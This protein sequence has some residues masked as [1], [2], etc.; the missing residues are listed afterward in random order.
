MGGR[1]EFR[2]ASEHTIGMELEFQ[3]LDAASFDL[4][5][6]ILPLLARHGGRGSVKPELVQ[7]SVEV[8]SGI[9]RGLAELAEDLLGQ[10]ADLRASATASGV[11]LAGSGTHPFCTRLGRVT[12]TLRYRAIE[13][14]EGY[15]ARIRTTFAAQVHVG[16]ESG[17]EAI[18]VMR[19]MR[20]YI[21]LLLAISANSPFWKG[22]DT[23]YASFR[24]QVL[25]GA[26]TYGLPPRFTTWDHYLSF[27][28]AARRAGAFTN[29]RDPHWDVRPRPDFGS[30]EVRVMDAQV[31]VGAAVRLG[32]FVQALIERI[33]VEPPPVQPQPEWV[34]RENRSRAARWGLEGRYIAGEDGRTIPMRK[35]L[36]ETIEWVEPATV[37]PGHGHRLEELTRSLARRPGYLLQ[38]RELERTGDLRDVAAWVAGRLDDELASRAPPDAGPRSDLTPRS[39]G[40]RR[41]CVGPGTRSE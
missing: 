25:A 5:D 7:C 13:R 14:R 22:H 31:T 17:E 30:V 35:L 27:I 40:T 37:E 26:R 32:A 10:V 8:N 16:L 33:R 41:A 21:P 39:R 29:F 28:R 15:G 4:A 2:G 23:G 3:I 19:C 24:Q 36:D 9:C 18:R 6:R 38:R 12:P 34:E 20:P 1:V 11:V